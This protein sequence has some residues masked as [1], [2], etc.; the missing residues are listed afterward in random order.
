MILQNLF[1][2]VYAYLYTYLKPVVIQRTN[3]RNKDR[4][5]LSTE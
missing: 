3:Q 1:F 4:E 5:N 2:S